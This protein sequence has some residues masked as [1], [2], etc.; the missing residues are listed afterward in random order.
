MTESQKEACAR[1]LCRLRDIDPDGDVACP[2]GFASCAFS[3]APAW[4]MALREIEEP[5]LLQAVENTLK[6][7]ATESVPT[8]PKMT[9]ETERNRGAFDLAN[10]QQDSRVDSRER[11]LRLLVRP[12]LPCVRWCSHKWCYGLSGCALPSAG[13]RPCSPP[14]PTG[15]SPPSRFA[16]P[17]RTAVVVAAPILAL[18]FALVV[19]ALI[20]FL[21]PGSP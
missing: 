9:T 5:E 19:A 18:A 13:L 20:E 1:E 16:L 11:D 6:K 15:D 12:R 17:W 4:K 14:A 7:F 8:E 2:C 10:S 21:I 3:Y